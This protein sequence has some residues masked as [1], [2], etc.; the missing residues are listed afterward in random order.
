MNMATR[1][2]RTLLH[3][4]LRDLLFRS[5]YFTGRPNA[6]FQQNS[7]WIFTYLK[8]ALFSNTSWFNG[9]VC[10]ILYITTLS[11]TAVKVKVHGLYCF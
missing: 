9:P 11:W 2:Y 6:A 8:K 3:K 4:L 1:G 10:Y 7:Q 5:N